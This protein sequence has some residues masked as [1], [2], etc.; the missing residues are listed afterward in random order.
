MR[1]AAA[2]IAKGEASLRAIETRNSKQIFDVGGELYETCLNC[3]QLYLSAIR[4]ALKWCDSR[5][6]TR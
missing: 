3:H 6:G 4:D 2:L 1:L 5:K